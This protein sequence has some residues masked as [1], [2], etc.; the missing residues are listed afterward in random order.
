MAEVPG[1]GPL[2]SGGPVRV[3]VNGPL[4]RTRCRINIFLLYLEELQGGDSRPLINND[5][6]SERIG[7][8]MCGQV[9]DKMSTRVVPRTPEY[10]RGPSC[11][12]GFLVPAGTEGNLF[13][14][15][16]TSNEK[17]DI[18]SRILQSCIKYFQN[19][20]SFL[21]LVPLSSQ[22]VSK[23][24]EMRG[25]EVVVGDGG[26]KGH[27]YNPDPVFVDSYFTGRVVDRVY[28][29]GSFISSFL[30]V[31]LVSDGY[32]TLKCRRRGP[33]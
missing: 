1:C 16:T 32:S 17:S 20:L 25:K 5:V 26:N 18:H 12:R 27:G 22:K 31:H 3:S 10:E 29:H 14:S 2:G 13:S 9:N 8:T 24:R 15:G 7:L 33:K 4:S 19:T 21:C 23:F 11:F 6:E 30:G 28:E